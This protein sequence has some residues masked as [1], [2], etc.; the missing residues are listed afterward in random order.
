[1]IGVP[2]GATKRG[3]CEPGLSKSHAGSSLPREEIIIGDSIAEMRKMPPA[4]VDL[5]FADPPYNL[6]LPG[7]LLLRPDQ[8]SVTG[9]D[10]EWDRF[11]N[12]AEYDV[13]TRNWLRAAR[14][15]M[16]P[17]TTIF[18]IG[19][20]HNIFRVGAI[21]QDLGFWILNDIIWRKANPMPNIRGR[22]VTNA[23]ETMIW[24][25]RGPEFKSYTFNYETLKG[26]NHDS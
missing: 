23:H 11:A 26:S 7:P 20:Y 24:A 4:S 1:M 15:V 5:V 14:R 12:F 22:R 9:V 17:N 16:K 10:D 6:Q 21:L 13:F 25:A 19:S 2:T 3:F 8:S 18:V